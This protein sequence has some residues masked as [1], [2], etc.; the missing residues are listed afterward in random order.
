MA[1]PLPGRRGTCLVDWTRWPHRVPARASVRAQ[2]PGHPSGAA[3]SSWE[4]TPGPLVHLSSSQE[5]GWGGG[6]HAVQV[7]RGIGSQCVTAGHLPGDEGGC[8]GTVALAL[9]DGSRVPGEAGPPPIR[10]SEPAKHL[11]MSTC[12]ANTGDKTKEEVGS[13]VGFGQD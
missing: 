8:P 5:G 9:C 4:W 11:S 7:H 10:L 2:H 1:S 13:W 12:E 6:R 3:T